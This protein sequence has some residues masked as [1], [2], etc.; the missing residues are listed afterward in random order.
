MRAKLLLPILAAALLCLAA[1]NFEDWGGFD[2]YRQDFHYSYP[3]KSTG[4]LSVE[5]FNGSVEVSGWDQETV[6]ISGAKYGST[7]EAADE[8]KI[9]IDN[10]PDSV[11]IRVTRPSYHHANMGARFIIKIPRAAY[12]DRIFTSNG[13]IRTLDGSGP[14]RLRTSNGAIRVQA[15]RGSL[16]A[17]TSNGSVELIDI[18]GDANAHTSNGHIRA[19]GQRGGLEADT[20]NGSINARFEQV[21]AGR[22]VRLDT[23][24]SS[25][26]LSLPANFANDIRVSTRNGG[27]TVHMPYEVHAHVMARTTNSSISSDFEVRMQ[28]EFSKNRLEGVIGNGGPLIDLSTSNG[29]IRLLKM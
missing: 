16:E 6:D 17:Q 20:S 27:I 21:P 8:L 4:R 12:V 29:S 15:L 22:P 7:Q 9:A 3:L 10:S 18:D 24:N 23:S 28:G 19:E 13:S 14:A 11:S 5:T 1:C 2:R 25:V 26:E